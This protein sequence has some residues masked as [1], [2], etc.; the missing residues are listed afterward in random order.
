MFPALALGYKL[1]ELD[2]KDHK[3]VQNLL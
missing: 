2:A 3:L 1:M